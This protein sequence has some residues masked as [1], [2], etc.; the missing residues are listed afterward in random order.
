M[1]KF[2]VL[3][4]IISTLKSWSIGLAK[5]LTFEDNFKGYEWSGSI[6]AG[7]EKRITHGLGVVP[8]RFLVTLSRDACTIVASSENRPTKDFFYI[9]NIASTSTFI[10]RVL[11]LP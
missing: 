3:S 1:A 10:G 2:P 11:I 9:K 4:S 6:E 8:T 5:G 7:V